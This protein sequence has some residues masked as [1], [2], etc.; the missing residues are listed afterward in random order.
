MGQYSVPSLCPSCTEPTTI[1]YTH[2]L[3]LWNVPYRVSVECDVWTQVRLKDWANLTLRRHRRNRRSHEERFQTL[4]WVMIYQDRIIDAGSLGSSEMRHMEL[5]HLDSH[6]MEV[7]YVDIRQCTE[8][9]RVNVLFKFW[10]KMV[11]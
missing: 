10:S 3:Q 2:L 11:F 1:K 6:V 7:S 9:Q 8:N 4:G 5:S